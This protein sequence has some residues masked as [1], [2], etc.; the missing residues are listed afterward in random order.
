MSGFSEAADC[1]RCG[2][3]KSFERSWD[4]CGSSGYCLEC[5][6]SF[7]TVDMD[8]QLTLEEVNE[9]RK[10]AEMPPLK[11]LKPAQTTWHS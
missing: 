3:E 11:E 4:D 9:E 6:Y 2:S 10:I 7:Y 8:T 1:P 5:G